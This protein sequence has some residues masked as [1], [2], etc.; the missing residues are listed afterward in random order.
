MRLFGPS[1]TLEQMGPPLATRRSCFPVQAPSP[2][3]S[4]Y[5]SWQKERNPLLTGSSLWSRDELAR[6]C[7]P[8]RL[9][10]NASTFKFISQ[11]PSARGL[12]VIH[13]GA[14]Q[15]H[16]HVETVPSHVSVSWHP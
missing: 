9:H 5:K 3:Q 11:H 13:E 14:T 6:G 1:S 8:L 12:P 4:R 10:M 7:D 16:K 2:N 15:S